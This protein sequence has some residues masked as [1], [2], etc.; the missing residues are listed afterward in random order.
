MVICHLLLSK[1][2]QN[3]FIYFILLFLLQKY[4]A[5][6]MRLNKTQMVIIYFI[7]NIYA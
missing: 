6:Q 7:Y 2:C 3:L 5:S 1:L 4:I